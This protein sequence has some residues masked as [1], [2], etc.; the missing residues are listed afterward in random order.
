HR[1]WTML[2]HS[3]GGL[4]NAAVLATNLS[5][6]GKTIA[7][8]LDLLVD[9][10]LVRRLTPWHNNTGKRLVKSPK[11]YV[12]DSG[13]VHA[14]LRL[15]DKE[16]VLGHPIVGNSWEGFVIENLLAVAPE[17]TQAGFYRTAAGAEI[18]LVL[19][20]PGNQLWT[21]EIKRNLTPKLG[22][23]YYSACLDLQPDRRYIVYTGTERFILADGV[24][25]IGLFDLMQE[26]L[27]LS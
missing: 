1:L 15:R 9:L 24:I 19:S 18:D 2:A 22:K 13:I 16:E 17:G 23:G 8:Y 11:V 14:L 7:R 4:L 21:V 27:C 26:I 12:R 20:L 6:D 5:I 3:Q 10:L 25:A